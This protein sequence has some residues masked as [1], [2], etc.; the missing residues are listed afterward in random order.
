[1]T[2]AALTLYELNSLVH[3]VLCIRLNGLYWVQAELARISDGSGHCYMELVQ[4]DVL[5]NTPVATAKAICWSSTWHQLLPKFIKTTGEMPRQGMTLMLQVK[6]NFHPAYG[7]SWMIADIDPTYTMGD[8]A[9]RRLEIINQLKQEGVFDLQRELEIPMFAQRIAVISSQTAAGYGDFC[10]QLVTNNPY[11]IQ[12]HTQLFPAIMQGE[13]VES[14]II[15]ALDNIYKCIDQF[16]LVVI[17][18]GG[19]STS[20]LSGFDTLPLAENV[21]NFPLPI[22]TGIGHERDESILDM[23]SH[24]RVKTPTAAADFII[25]HHN[26]LMLSLTDYSE[27]IADYVVNRLQQE[28]DRLDN[29]TRKIPMLFA[30]VKTQQQAKIERL[31]S[32]LTLSVTDAI[33]AGR[34]RLERLQD[35]LTT[36]LTQK[37]SNE[38]HRLSLLSER[39]KMLDP[40]L[41]LK[42]GYSITL[43]NGRAV[44]DATALN[45]GDDI[46]TIT[47]S[48][49]LTSVIKSKQS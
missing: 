44:K 31:Q 47:A 42:R 6:A 48:G 8:M 11:G 26:E 13:Q 19:G 32:R 4:K 14:S 22:I 17:I 1:M 5:S 27:R 9:R 39:I 34:H 18:R 30:L 15:A 46:T 16:D 40:Q 33:S 3:D 28:H 23:V 12:F 35:S 37:I 20:D 38:Q 43:H 45:I 10:N 2:Q 24:M 7:F 36:S 29:L 49:K 41:L 25:D 21:A